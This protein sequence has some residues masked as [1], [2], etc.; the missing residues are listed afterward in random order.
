[1]GVMGA[2]TALRGRVSVGDMG[3]MRALRD[4]GIETP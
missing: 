2:L 1:M 3:V 4:L